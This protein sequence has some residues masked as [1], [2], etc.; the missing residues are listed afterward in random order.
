MSTMDQRRD[1]NGDFSRWHWR[2]GRN[3]FA[4]WDHL[5]NVRP[6]ESIFVR[7]PANLTVSTVGGIRKL[8]MWN[9]IRATRTAAA[10][11]AVLVVLA[12]MQQGGP[13]ESAEIRVFSSAAPRGVFR[14]LVP[15]F[16]RTTGHRLLI[17]YEF[18]SDLKRRIEAGDPFDVAILPPDLA[19]DLMQR[20]KLGRRVARRPR[21]HRHRRRRAQGRAETRHQ[22]G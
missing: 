18:A 20:G 14:D 7:E 15:E 10:T 8:A 22:H 1:M 5:W 12:L 19:D 4:R 9:P 11:V 3:V 13:V 16:E 17:N 21:A 2:H 6:L